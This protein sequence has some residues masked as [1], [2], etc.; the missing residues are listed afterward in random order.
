MDL[1]IVAVGAALLGV[2][3]FLVARSLRRRAVRVERPVSERE[4]L[5]AER[6]AV[7]TALGELEADQAAG[8]LT[9]EDFAEQRG[10]LMARGA[11]ILRQ[12]D[13]LPAITPQSVPE[14][15]AIEAAIAE[16]RRRPAQIPLAEPSLSHPSTNGATVDV[17]VTR[18]DD[19]LEAAI[20]SRRRPRA[21]R[22]ETEP[23]AAAPVGAGPAC[24]HCGTAA[25]PGDRYC[26]ACGQALPL[27]RACAHCGEIAALDDRFCARCGSR[28]PMDV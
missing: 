28:L 10:A 8:K 4:T 11:A 21:A 23:V 17:A 12:L 27:P 22:L 18:L 24:A 6:D 14:S 7:L 9:P 13:S 20:L 3:V 25:E 16:R 15:D 19:P 5:S 2:L 1:V 26:G